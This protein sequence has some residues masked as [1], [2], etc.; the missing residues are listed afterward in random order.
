MTLLISRYFTKRSLFYSFETQPPWV[1]GLGFRAIHK[2]L[3]ILEFGNRSLLSDFS[4][5]SSSELGIRLR[6]Q[7]LGIIIMS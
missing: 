1:Q 4:K 3:Y 6:V 7:G 2:A 5:V